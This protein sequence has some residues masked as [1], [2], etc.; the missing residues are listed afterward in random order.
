MLLEQRGGSAAL[1]VRLGILSEEK[2]IAPTEQNLVVGYDY[3]QF[4]FP[5]PVL[6]PFLCRPSILLL[7]SACLK[8]STGEESMRFT[9]E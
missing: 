4:L 3:P 2:T 8:P 7:G 6:F 9:R 1:M 5:F